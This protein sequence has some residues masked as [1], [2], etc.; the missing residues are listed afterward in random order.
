MAPFSALHHQYCSHFHLSSLQVLQ[1]NLDVLWCDGHLFSMYGVEMKQYQFLLCFPFVSS[2]GNDML[3]HCCFPLLPS[4][5]FVQGMTH[6]HI[7]V[8]HLFLPHVLVF[9]IVLLFLHYHRLCQNDMSAMSVIITTRSF[10]IILSCSFF[11][12]P[13]SDFEVELDITCV[14]VK[15][16]SM[17]AKLLVPISSQFSWLFFT[18][19]RVAGVAG[20]PWPDSLFG[21]SN[22]IVVF[23][24]DLLHL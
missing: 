20:W 16:S 6:Y 7:V 5:F 21:P 10:V 8:F 14:V 18:C 24:L 1:G 11:S 23:W 12:F 3:P 19:A 9:Y 22:D 13:S 17:C 4:S 2:A 15:C